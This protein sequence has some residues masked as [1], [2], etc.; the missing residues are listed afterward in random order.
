M[1]KVKQKV[2]DLEI[3]DAE[4]RFNEFAYILHQADFRYISAFLKKQR[5]T[6]RLKNESS[7]L[8]KGVNGRSGEGRDFSDGAEGVPQ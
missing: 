5:Q 1:E 2:D 6:K 3:E 4:H 8:H 7:A